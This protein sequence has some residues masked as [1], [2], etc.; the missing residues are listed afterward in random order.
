MDK[1]QT[2]EKLFFDIVTYSYLIFPLT[3]LV[4]LLKTR[5]T[6]L[7]SVYG[8]I[9]FLLNFF[10]YLYTNLALRKFY[11]S[12]YTILEYLFFSWILWKEIRNQQFRIAMLILS[13]LFFTFQIF[14][15]YNS[16]MNHI[17]SVPVGIETILLLVY[18]LFFFYQYFKETDTNYIYNEPCFWLAF[19]ILIYLGGSFFFNILAGHLSEE[20][21]RKYWYITYIAEIIKN[22]LFVIAMILYARQTKKT[23]REKSMPYLDMTI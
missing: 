3:F 11:S 18:I 1:I 2:I 13:V 23:V 14:Y 15:Y 20:E 17:D 19:G 4:T 16:S 5:K 21:M 22:I 12:S 6:I 10:L 8:I 7:F 9:F